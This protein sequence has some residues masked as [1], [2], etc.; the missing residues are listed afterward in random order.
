MRGGRTDGKLSILT[1]GRA[2]F[3]DAIVP[4]LIPFFGLG[5]FL[6]AVWRPGVNYRQFIANLSPI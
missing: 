3:R 4:E 6:P 2:D 1:L 5:V